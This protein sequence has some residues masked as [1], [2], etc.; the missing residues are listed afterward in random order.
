MTRTRFHQGLEEL[1]H[2]LLAMGGMAFGWF[3]WQYHLLDPSLKF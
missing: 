2:K 3:C 1:K